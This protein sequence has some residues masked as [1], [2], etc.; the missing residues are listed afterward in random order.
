[1]SLKKS[2]LL[3]FSLMIILFLT[4]VAVSIWLLVRSNESLNAVNKEIRV[5]L[6]VIDPINH[7]RTLRVRLMEYMKE[8][9]VNDGQSAASLEGVKAAAEKAD[10]AFHAYLDSPR[11][12]GEEA[13]A[14]AYRQ[15]FLAYRNQGIQ[16]LIEAAEARDQARFRE[17]LPDVIRLDRAYE[18]ILDKVL[19]QHEA[20]AK[21]LNEDAQ[22]HFSSGVMLLLLIGSLFGLVVISISILMHRFVLT[23]LINAGKHLN[24][25]A[26]G[27]LDTPVPVKPASR[28][29]IQSLMGSLEAMRLSLILTRHFRTAF[30]S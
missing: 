21:K 15:A 18:I 29:E 3:V 16:P 13:E 5:V 20:Y 30:V 11:L 23:P 24:L 25:I 26:D 7:S 28:S 2:S 27:H 1:M 17:R 9:E 12:K 8:I 4:S 6:S 10:V 19:A 14:D 22:S